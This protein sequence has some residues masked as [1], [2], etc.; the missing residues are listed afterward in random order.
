MKKIIKMVHVNDG[1]SRVMHN[2]DFMFVE[3]FPRGEKIIE[4]FTNNG[5]TLVNR[6]QVIKP[7]IQ[8]EG[9]YS[10]YMNGW[11][12]MFE[13]EVEDEEVN[14]GDDI[15]RQVLDEMFPD[16]FD[17]DYE[18]EDLWEDD[19]D[20]LYLEDDDYEPYEY[21]RDEEFARKTNERIAKLYDDVR[22]NRVSIESLDALDLILINGLLKKEMNGE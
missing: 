8:K 17:D 2:G 22:N 11:D 20:D 14:N 9:V 1:D 13:K 12:L 7:A 18:D 5:W 19:D 4:A 3:T 21:K 15:L 6:T 16:Y 10:F